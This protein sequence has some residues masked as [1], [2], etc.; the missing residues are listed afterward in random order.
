MVIQQT[1]DGENA[2]GNER[3]PQ[4][5]PRALPSLPP[6]RRAIRAGEQGKACHTPGNGLSYLTWVHAQFAEGAR[7]WLATTG[8][9][10]VVS[11]VVRW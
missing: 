6:V 10:G 8:A 3:V 9:P 4:R 7:Y 1:E 11:T 5:A 2:S